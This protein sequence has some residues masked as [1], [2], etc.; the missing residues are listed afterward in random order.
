MVL[1]VER[2]APWVSGG[3]ELVRY[4]DGRLLVVDQGGRGAVVE[5]AGVYRRFEGGS[6]VCHLGMHPV[7]DALVD[8]VGQPPLC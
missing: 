2:M 7:I 5:S 3:G 4:V 6:K 8:L 1:R